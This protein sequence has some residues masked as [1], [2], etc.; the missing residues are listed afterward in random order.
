MID[1]LENI[2]VEHVR[3]GPSKIEKV[4]CLIMKLNERAEEFC[5]NTDSR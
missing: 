4:L 1:V 3:R 5:F 2:F